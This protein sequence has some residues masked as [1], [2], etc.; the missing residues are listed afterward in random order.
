MLRDRWQAA[1]V[2]NG[3]ADACARSK[4]AEGVGFLSLCIIRPNTRLGKQDIHSEF[5]GSGEN[6]WRAE[7]FLAHRSDLAGIFL[8]REAVFVIIY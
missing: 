2:S 3:P 6:V 8:N 4:S 1:F 7:F 5:A